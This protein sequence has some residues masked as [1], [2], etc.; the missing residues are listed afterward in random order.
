MPSR[1]SRSLELNFASVSPFSTESTVL[2]TPFFAGSL[3]SLSF[4]T[5]SS[6]SR[7]WRR[8]SAVALNFSRSDFLPEGLRELQLKLE[9]G[10]SRICASAMRKRL[11]LTTLLPAPVVVMPVARPRI[12]RVLNGS[13]VSA[14]SLEVLPSRPCE[15]IATRPG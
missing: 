9:K 3:S 10:R 7:N 11:S 5:F 14:K 15:L 6:Q 12:R 13:I 2:S 1:S 8:Y 4:L